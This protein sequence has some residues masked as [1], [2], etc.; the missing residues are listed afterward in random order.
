MYFCTYYHKARHSTSQIGTRE[1]FLSI[2][3]GLF[4]GLTLTSRKLW[5]RIEIIE[6]KRQFKL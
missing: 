2:G 4:M 5:D 1:N 6:R 3:L